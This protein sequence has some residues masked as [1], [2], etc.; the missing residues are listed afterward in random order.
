[1]KF[2]RTTKSF[3][4]EALLSRYQAAGT[5]PNDLQTIADADYAFLFSGVAAGKVID[6]SGMQ[7]VLADAPIV[8]HVPQSVSRAQAKIALNRAGLLDQ[9]NAIVAAADIETQ[10]AWNEALTFERSSP[11]VAKLAA[12]LNL[13]SD[14]LDA[15]FITAAGITP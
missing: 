11:T 5:V 10:L 13:S 7:P 2:S 12:A 9:V 1:M 14:Q 8:K 15:L 6:W 3:Y 4:P